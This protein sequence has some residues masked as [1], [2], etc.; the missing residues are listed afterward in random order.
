MI[1]QK[2][3]W[4]VEYIY[5]FEKKEPVPWSSIFCACPF[6]DSCYSDHNKNAMQHVWGPYWRTINNRR[7]NNK[8]SGSLIR[9]CSIYFLLL[10]ELESLSIK[11]MSL[12]FERHSGVL[13]KHD[14]FPDCNCNKLYRSAENGLR[15]LISSWWKQ[16]LTG[17]N[18]IALTG[19]IY[20]ELNALT[21]PVATS[22]LSHKQL[23]DVQT[24]TTSSDYNV[25][26]IH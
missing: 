14:F 6:K 2:H 18:W 20:S 10:I 15:R 13:T 3:R 23:P 22:W 11:K 26:T 25:R 16:A 5:K 24:W 7:K 21:F 4:N 8:T 1:Y 17:L 12:H 9:S 19:L